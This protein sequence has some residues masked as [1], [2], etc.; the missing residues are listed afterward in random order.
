MRITGVL[1]RWYRSFN[2][3]TLGLDDIEPRQPWNYRDGQSFP[4]VHVPL[5]SRITS[6]VGANESGKSH[7][8]AA[9]SKV[10]NGIGL[11]GQVADNYEIKD[12]CR[13]NGFSAFDDIFPEI[14][15]ELSA[16]PSE[17]SRLEG[18]DDVLPDSAEG[19]TPPVRLTVIING[20]RDTEYSTLYRG[21]VVVKTFS[22][23][24]WSE[25]A[26]TYLPR[27]E[28]LDSKLA[29]PNDVHVDELID[30]FKEKKVKAVVD[31]LFAQDFWRELEPI[32]ISEPGADVAS[33]TAKL[34]QLKQA[35]GKHTRKPQANELPLVYQLFAGVLGVKLADLVRMRAYTS[36]ERGYVSWINDDINSRIDSEL[37]ITRYWD[38]D[39][40]FRLSVNYKAGTFHFQITDRTGCTYTFNERSSGLRYFLSYY[41]QAK[42]LERRHD[43]RGAVILMDE[44]DNFLSA[45]GQRSL[46]RVFESLVS[47][48][49]ARA[50]CQLIYTTHSP[51]LINRNFPDRVKLVRKGDG[52]EGTQFVPRAAV[53]RFE[54]VRSALSI[55]AADTLFLGSTNV[56]LEGYSDQKLLAACIQRF[57]EPGRLDDFLDLNSCTLVAAGGAPFAPHLIEKALRGDEKAPVVVVLL[58][59]DQPGLAA[60]QKLITI[61]DAKQASTLREVAAGS[62]VFQVLE[63]VVPV[64]I[65]DRA[66][67]AF[68]KRLGVTWSE[69]FQGSEASGNRAEQIVAYCTKADSQ[70]AVMS[71]VEI[72]AGVIDE[73]VEL[74]ADE[75]FHMSELAELRANTVSLCRHINGMVEHALRSAN[76]RSLRS[77]VR[78]KVELFFK[79][80][81]NSA[82]KGDLN[83]LLHDI[84][85]I[86]FGHTDD[87]EQTR[88]N[89]A[90]LLEQLDAEN[91]ENAQLIDMS[92]WKARLDRFKNQPWAKVKDWSIVASATT[93]TTQPQSN[94][95]QAGSAD[96]RT[97]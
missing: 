41:I 18:R 12:I 37:D 33:T 50:T 91:H 17:A 85:F 49:T 1:L 62:T 68:G 47:A 55:D 9:I 87:Y 56:V 63:D 79:R 82:S 78:Q 92:R 42:A 19:S 21:D 45:S 26:K 97:H 38:Q 30:T 5:E 53:R 24:E 69:P 80:F 11:P 28:F 34:E 51:F 29:L 44:P 84:T 90:R 70:F 72:R 31:P 61:L 23:D 27:V 73:V 3:L 39:E 2:T 59:G 52:S 13:Y 25:L 75:S 40:D 10:I 93:T 95:S 76:Q 74:L 8:L 32:S 58:D 48:K 4:F 77:L 67:Q 60:Y 15:L 94:D 64:A 96:E 6:I 89:V 83:K 54:P 57:G 71:S 35:V 14:G 66:L 46:L 7:L 65:L 20:E 16:S 86:V 22:R 88:R 36:T 43:D 81:P